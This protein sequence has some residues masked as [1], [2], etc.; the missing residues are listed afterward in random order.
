MTRSPKTLRSIAVD[1]RLRFRSVHLVDFSMKSAAAD[2]EL[3]G[4][5]GHV[6]I[7]SRKSLGN[8]FSFR[9]VQIERTCL[10]AESLS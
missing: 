6:A 9:L 4:R 10:F 3:F 5:G 1:F 7:R 2:A 8:Q